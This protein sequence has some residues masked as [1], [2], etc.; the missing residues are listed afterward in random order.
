MNRV[1]KIMH[2]HIFAIA[3][4]PLCILQHLINSVKCVLRFAYTDVQGADPT[5]PAKPILLNHIAQLAPILTANQ[6]AIL[7]VQAGLVGPWGEWHGSTNFSDDLDGRKEIV[8]ALLDAVPDRNVQIRTPLHKQSL[9]GSTTP[10][11]LIGWGY[12][13]NGEF[14]WDVSSSWS[15]YMDGYAVDTSDFHGGI[16]SVKVTNGAAKQ[17]IDLPNV[18]EGNLIEITGWSKR[19]GATG[20]APWDY[21]VYAD[22]KYSDNTYLWGQLAQFNV[23]FIVR[24]YCSLVNM[25]FENVLIISF[26]SFAAK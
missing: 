9:Y 23:S 18:V 14:E 6:D 13:T 15:P 10:P 25:Y 17:F 22:V 26:H 5:E 1:C 8:S 19:V 11:T 21:A 24:I 16:Q 20:A 12:V 7:A 3:S 4:P 2:Y